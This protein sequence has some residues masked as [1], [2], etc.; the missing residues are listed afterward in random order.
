[1]DSHRTPLGTLLTNVLVDGDFLW[2]LFL[3]APFLF[4]FSR[5][6]LSET[7]HR[8]MV[9]GYENNRRTVGVPGQLACEQPYLQQYLAVSLTYSC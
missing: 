4:L 6:N 5:L 7:P 8:K 9:D 3:F 2:F 1:M